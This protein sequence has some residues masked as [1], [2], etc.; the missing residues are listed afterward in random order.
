M[1]S[2]LQHE[3]T[4]LIKEKA[5]TAAIALQDNYYSE[6]ATESNTPNYAGITCFNITCCDK[7]HMNTIWIL[8]NGTTDHMCSNKSSFNTLQLLT[9][10]ITVHLHDGIVVQ[11]SHAWSISL[12][13]SLKLNNVLYIPKFLNSIT[14]FSLLANSSKIIPKSNDTFHLLYNTRPSN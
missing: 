8:D 14:I 11:V 3:V 5:T 13:A 7:K 12:F 2:S 4:K 1:L 6:N 10:C 9:K